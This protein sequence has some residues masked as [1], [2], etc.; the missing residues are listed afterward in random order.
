M[1]DACDATR[2]CKHLKKCVMSSK[3]KKPSGGTHSLLKMGFE[4][5]RMAASSQKHNKTEPAKT[6][7]CPGIMEIDDP[8]LPIYLHC[9]SVLGGGA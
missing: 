3:K 6:C 2:W 9:M 5:M 7:P 8:Q 4:S 1:K